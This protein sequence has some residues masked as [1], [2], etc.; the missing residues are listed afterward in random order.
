M[1]FLLNPH[2]D[3]NLVGL[4]RTPY[5]RIPDQILADWIAKKKDI[6]LG[7]QSKKSIWSFLLTIDL[8]KETGF[9]HIKHTIQKIKSHF[10]NTEKIGITQSFQNALESLG[11]IDLSYYQEYGKLTYGS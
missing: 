6:K 4:L 1:R 2:D 10:E 7:K 3:E 9:K 5:C 8:N 11:F